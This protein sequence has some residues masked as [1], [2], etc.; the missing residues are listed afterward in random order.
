MQIGRFD[1]HV[2]RGRQLSAAAGQGDHGLG[3]ER[4]LLRQQATQGIVHRRLTV[5]GSVL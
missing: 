5:A 2:R 3:R 1:A 4:L